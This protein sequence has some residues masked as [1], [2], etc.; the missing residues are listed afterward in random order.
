M[1]ARPALSTSGG[2]PGPAQLGA[3]AR[4]YLYL[5]ARRYMAVPLAAGFLAL[6]A[7]VFPSTIPGLPAGPLAA[8]GLA[9]GATL[10]G[11]RPPAGSPSPYTSALDGGGV[12]GVS[13]AL[14]GLVAP[15]PPGAVAA[16]GTNPSAQPANPPDVSGQQ[17]TP[18]DLSGRQGSPSAPIPNAPSGPGGVSCPLP[19]LSLPGPVI[20]EAYSFLQAVAGL[21]DVATSLPAFAS[22]LPAIVAALPSDLES[23]QL[24]S[25]VDQLIQEVAFEVVI[26]LVSAAPLPS[27]TGNA[28]G[29]SGPS[30]AVTTSAELNA[31]AVLDGF[32]HRA[33]MTSSPSAQQGIPPGPSARA[34]SSSTGPSCATLGRSLPRSATP[35]ALALVQAVTGLCEMAS[36]LP[37]GLATGPLPSR[38]SELIQQVA[39]HVVVPLE[40]LQVVPPVR[41]TP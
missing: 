18:P 28:P 4:K 36:P 5:L 8:T 32:V 31:L 11:T 6:V 34:P 14:A 13:R 29:T 16:D 2:E 15:A 1:G 27:S 33:E 21:C 20:P 12:A 7:S 35:Q 39:D 23:G 26:P 9:P 25:Q 10:A 30:L 38:V 24:P 3:H 40:T 19:E 37:S 22:Q 41:E 17:G